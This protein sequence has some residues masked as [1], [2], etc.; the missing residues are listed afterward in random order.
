MLAQTAV[1][2]H[3][4]G[5]R[6]TIIIFGCGKIISCTRAREHVRDMQMRA[7]SSG[8]VW[9]SSLSTMLLRWI[10]FRAG[11]CSRTAETMFVRILRACVR[12]CAPVFAR[13]TWPRSPQRRTFPRFVRVDSNVC[14]P[15]NRCRGCYRENRND[16]RASTQDHAI[17]RLDC[18]CNCQIGHNGPK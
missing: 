8:V 4:R 18:D 1:V 12:V 16:V 11:S 6:V 10:P 15:L 5:A 3:H 17:D 13:Y 7:A 2:V 14:S 9:S